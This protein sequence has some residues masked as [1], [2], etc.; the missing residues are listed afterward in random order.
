M[1]GAGHAKTHA[2]NQTLNKAIITKTCLSG[3]FVLHVGGLNHPRINAI[4]NKM[5]GNG[6]R[7]FHLTTI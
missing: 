7:E 3:D 6:S 2:G 1:K 5:A 4:L